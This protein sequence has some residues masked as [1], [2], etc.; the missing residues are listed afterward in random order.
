MNRIRV[1]VLPCSLLACGTSTVNYR[2]QGSTI[3]S[4]AATLYVDSLGALPV[5]AHDQSNQLAY[6]KELDLF[7]FCNGRTWIAAGNRDSDQAAIEA[8]ANTVVAWY[9]FFEYPADLCLDSAEV[10]CFFTGGDAAIYADGAANYTALTSRTTEDPFSF[11]PQK[12]L[13]LELGSAHMNHQAYWDTSDLVIMR[14]VVRHDVSADI[15]LHYDAKVENFSVY[16]DRDQNRQ[17]TSA[18]EFLFE[19]QQMD[20]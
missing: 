7:R 2:N 1:L 15:L 18:D 4:P 5:C 16:F 11:E 20:Q 10:A 8:T 3:D 19:P 6:I 9:R 14:E 17:A 12:E 13:L